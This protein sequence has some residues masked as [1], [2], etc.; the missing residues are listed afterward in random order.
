MKI[1][2]SYS[3]KDRT[4]A[5]PIYLALRAQRHAVFFDRSDLPAGEEYDVRIRE[6]IEDADLFLFLVSPD[7][8]HEGSYTLTELAI[9][10]KT[11]PHPGGKVLPVLVRPTELDKLPP[12][13]LAVTVLEPVGNMPASIADAVHRIATAKWR[14]LRN[15]LAG[16]LGATVVLGIGIHFSVPNLFG[17]VIGQQ[18][19][20]ITGKDRAQALLVPAGK[21]QMGDDEWSPKREVYVDAFY[22][23]KYEVSLSLYAAFLNATDSKLKPE[24]WS[25]INLAT[26]G[27]L[28]VVGVNWHEAEAYCRWAGKRLP[29]EAEWEKAA[30]GTDGRLYPWGENEPIASLA[31]FG[32]DSSK[33]FVESLEPVTSHESGKSPWGIYNLAGNAAEWVADW[34]DEGFTKGAVWNPT[35]PAAGDGKVLRGGSWSDASNALGTARRFHV[36][37]DDRAD[38]RG[39]RCVQDLPK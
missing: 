23:D 29:T 17:K 12:Y 21:F 27:T 37:P 30:R 25:D 19:N 16:G 4:L 39:F 38:D 20:M 8:L 35:G 9:A 2:L 34:Y 5:E 33:P 32:K 13:L 6:A 15:Y 36:N 31:N 11:W 26:Q 14:R 7:A 10:Q 3:S 28:P 18:S 22:M 1:F 24:Y